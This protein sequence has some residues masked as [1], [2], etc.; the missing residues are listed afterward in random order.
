MAK[1]QYK[2]SKTE[3]KYNIHGVDTWRVLYKAE[4][5]PLQKSIGIRESW[6]LASDKMFYTEEDAKKELNR[7]KGKSKR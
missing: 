2:I 5:T 6:L 7:L 3:A 1:M 4:P